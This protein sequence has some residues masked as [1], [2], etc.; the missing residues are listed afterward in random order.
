MSQTLVLITGGNRG[1]GL[2]LVESFLSQPNYVRILVTIYLINASRLTS[3]TDCYFCQPG[4]QPSNFKS[5]CRLAQ[6]WRQQSCCLE[7]RCWGWAGCLWPCEVSERRACNWSPWYCCRQCRHLKV[8]PSCEGCPASWYPRTY[9][10]QCLRC[11][12]FI[13]GHTRSFAK[14]D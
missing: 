10:Y 7:I 9:R 2:G 5:T 3:K 14:V 11:G 4:H 6:G 1:L 12:I 13:P 8:L